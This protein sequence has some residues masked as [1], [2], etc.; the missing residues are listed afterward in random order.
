MN[1]QTKP[2]EPLTAEE[3]EYWQILEQKLVAG[4]GSFYI[5]QSDFAKLCQEN[6]LNCSTATARRKLRRIQEVG[7][8]V[9]E[10]KGKG[11]NPYKITWLE[12]GDYKKVDNTKQLTPLTGTVPLDSPLYLTREADEVCIQKL[13]AGASREGSRPFIRIRAPKQ[14]GKSSLL[15]RIQAFLEK[16][17]N[18]VV[19]FVDLGDADHFYTNVFDD[20]DILLYQF[21]C[22]LSKT[23]SDSV[24]RLRLNDL[25]DLPELKENW[26]E[27]LTPQLKCANY[28]HDHIFLPI[29]Q[30]KTLL[31]DGI[32]EVL[33]KP[34][35]DPFLK[36]LRSWNEKRMKVVSQAPIIWPS[37]VIAYSTEPY[38]VLGMRG[39]VLQ[40]VGTVVELKEFNQNQ[41]LELSTKYDLS[42]RLGEEDIDFLMRLTGGHPALSNQA[43]YQI[44]Q[45]MTLHQLEYKAIQPDG[46]FWNELSRALELLENNH[47]LLQCFQKILKGDNCNDD[48]AKFQLMKAGLLKIEDDTVK[49]IELYRNY[50]DG[51]F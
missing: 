25:K 21:T 7:R 9:M 41:L 50:F 12:Y 31:I 6:S 48:L 4:N 32:D 15:R 36:F 24:H 18:H 23:F 51:H 16:Q 42:Q 26:H 27:N 17:Q 46:P 33:G 47:N 44:S 22:A 20:L 39:S 19:G 49:V 29:K 28:L 40:N 8:I 10:R 1:Q 2:I 5:S 13:K 38:S 34:T 43:L 14:M 11:N 37:I 3:E 45:G 30:P 35:Q